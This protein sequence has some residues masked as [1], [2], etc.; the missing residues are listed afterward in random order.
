[1]G[2]S[3]VRENKDKFI[4]I[5]ETEPYQDFGVHKGDEI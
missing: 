2:V 1:M 5:L 4:G 3:F